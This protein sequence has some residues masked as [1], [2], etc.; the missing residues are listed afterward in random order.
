MLSYG[1][2][3]PLPGFDGT[4]EALAWIDPLPR[5]DLL[6][7]VDLVRARGVVTA[8]TGTP[9][10]PSAPLTPRTWLRLSEVRR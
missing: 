4:A 5:A 8:H 2:H 1:D 10:R 3:A 7:V 6:D 9:W